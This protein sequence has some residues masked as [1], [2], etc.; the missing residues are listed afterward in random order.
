VGLSVDGDFLIRAI[1]Q[2]AGGATIVVDDPVGHMEQAAPLSLLSRRERA[3]LDALWRGDKERAITRE[4]QVAVSTVKRTIRRLKRKLGATTLLQLGG[5]AALLGL[6]SGVPRH[7][8]D[9]GSTR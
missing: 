3:V 8:G 2:V 7:D 5:H 9:M 1:V 6:V 4:Q